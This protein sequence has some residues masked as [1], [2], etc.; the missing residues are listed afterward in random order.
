MDDEHVEFRAGRDHFG[1]VQWAA[2]LV[3]EREQRADG[4][5]LKVLPAYSES[6]EAAQWVRHDDV[7]GGR[8]H[9]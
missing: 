6:E 2:G 4:S 3:V 7:R 1:Q 9:V 5:W 8:P